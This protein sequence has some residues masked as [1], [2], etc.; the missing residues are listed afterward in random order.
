MSI[1][2][3]PAL[4]VYEPG[5]VNSNKALFPSTFG[6]LSPGFTL[7]FQGSYK[8]SALQ[9][10]AISTDNA[11]IYT[12]QFF[13]EDGEGPTPEAQYTVTLNPGEAAGDPVTI[14]NV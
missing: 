3:L 13:S 14:E 1:R 10:V 4:T 9:Y 7:I 2:K 11:A 5:I 6:S 8:P 12:F